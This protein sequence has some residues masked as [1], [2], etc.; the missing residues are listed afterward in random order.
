MNIR[1]LPGFIYRYKI[2]AFLIITSI[3]V[4]VYHLNYWSVLCTNFESRR[5][6]SEL[7]N[8]QNNGNAV[9]ILCSPLCNRKEIHS[10][11]CENLH[12]GK[13]AV[14][15]AQWESTKLVFKAAKTEI[16]IE[17]TEFLLWED[18]NG[19]KHYPSETEFASMMKDVVFN[20]LNYTMST[21]QLERL[22]R[23]QA[24][25]IETETKKRQLEMEYVWSLIQKQ[26]Y[27]M[28]ILFEDKDVF[29]QLIGTCGTFYAVEYIKPIETQITV[30]VLSDSMPE[31]SRRVKLAIMILDL[32]QDLETVFTEP[33]HICD[34]RINH[35]GLSP[36]GQKLKYLDLDDVYPKSVLNKK[37][38]T[39]KK[40]KRNTDC[41]ILGCRSICSKNKRC[42]SPVTNNNLQLICEKIFLDWPISRLIISPGLLMSKH[43]NDSLAILLRQCA[44][45]N[46]DMSQL[47]RVAAPENLKLRL[48]NI[49][50]DMDKEL[51]S[52][53][54]RK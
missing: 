25:K 47:S 20:K 40:C 8:R 16:N 23:L 41:D 43:T 49:L 17:Q 36:G 9:G 27:I 2:V 50:S 18:A 1:R 54:P 12:V 39:N 11:V 4:I 24:S 51:S 37:V 34:V 31:W 19:F 21:H 13:E 5:F 26:E 28:T 15:S 14:F 38:N 7:C 32:L 22:S 29:P 44:N 33:F 52:Q 35:F 53:L 46:G 10:L 45:P 3:F 30:F 48:Y 6:V 42:E